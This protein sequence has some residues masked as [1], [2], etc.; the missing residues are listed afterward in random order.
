MH[1]EKTLQFFHGG[2]DDV[3]IRT[4]NPI[5]GRSKHQ[6]QHR[7]VRVFILAAGIAHV[8]VDAQQIT[9]AKQQVINFG[10][11]AIKPEVDVDDRHPI[12]AFE[13]LEVGQLLPSFRH[14]QLERI[15]RH[16]THVGICFQG[17][18]LLALDPADAEGFHAAIIVKLDFP[19]G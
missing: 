8:R 17:A 19:Q 5:L 9:A 3:V 11:L 16:G 15:H 14:Q 4:A 10:E 13:L 2:R 6:L 12:E 1:R 7:T 18:G